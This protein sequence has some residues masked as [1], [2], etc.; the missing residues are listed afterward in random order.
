[1]LGWEWPVTSNRPYN[2]LVIYECIDSVS[3][4]GDSQYP[5]CFNLLNACSMYMDK[6]FNA[7]FYKINDDVLGG[8]R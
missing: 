4:G 6:I 5:L 7:V 3:A 2:R 1:M 8:L